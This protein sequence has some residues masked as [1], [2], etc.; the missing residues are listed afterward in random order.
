MVRAALPVSLALLVYVDAWGFFVWAACALAVIAPGSAAADSSRNTHLKRLIGCMSMRCLFRV[1][2][3][4]SRAG[5]LEGQF[6]A[7]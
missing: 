2:L 6:R 3:E 5:Q 7:N 4:F 1:S